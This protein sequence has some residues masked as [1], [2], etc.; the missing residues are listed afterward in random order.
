MSRPTMVELRTAYLDGYMGETQE[1]CFKRGLAA[2][3]TR[4]AEVI[5][6]GGC[7]IYVPDWLRA[8]AAEA[9]PPKPDIEAATAACA[10]A[11]LWATKAGQA[12]EAASLAAGCAEAAARRADAALEGKR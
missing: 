5:A 11:R 7:S 1:D 9:D 12:S 8:I 4:L 3:L 10:N 6:G 2:V